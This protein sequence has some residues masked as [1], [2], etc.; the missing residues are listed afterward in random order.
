MAAAVLMCA[1]DF[2]SA[3]GNDAAGSDPGP[4]VTMLSSM[5][6]GVGHEALTERLTAPR[7]TRSEPGM[8]SAAWM[9]VA[10]VPG[11]RADLIEL[12]RRWW[13][14]HRDAA[15]G[16]GVGSVAYTVGSHET[17]VDEAPGLRNAVPSLSVGLRYRVA[18][19][20]AIYADAANARGLYGKGSDAYFTKVGVEW[21]GSPRSGWSLARGG[22]GL[23]ID[24]GKT[25][26]MR[27]KGGGLGV[28]LRSKF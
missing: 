26:T 16:L 19:D 8:P 28:Y 4:D 10:G 14:T 7:Y 9:P 15:I 11:R 25:M 18:A 21:Q 2:T 22:I 1:A 24:S 12:S 3:E 13:L 5:P 27:I 17:R 23:R 20:A 6:G